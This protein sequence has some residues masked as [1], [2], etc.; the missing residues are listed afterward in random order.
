MY[1]KVIL[2]YPIFFGER[3]RC[4]FRKVVVILSIVPTVSSS[5]EQSFRVLQ[6]SKTN[7]RSTMEQDRLSHL[8]LFFIERAYVSRVDFQPIFSPKMLVIYFGSC[9]KYKL[10]NSML[11]KGN[12]S[13]SY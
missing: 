8:T 1:L 3:A 10:V 7:L 12:L 11:A 13:L 4:N 5:L 9:K 2:C 6:R